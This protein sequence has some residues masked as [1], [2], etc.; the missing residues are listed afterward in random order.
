MAD[1]QFVPYSDRQRFLHCTCGRAGAEVSVTLGGSF[2]RYT[3]ATDSTRRHVYRLFNPRWVL[4]QSAWCMRSRCF[5][6]S[7]C[8]RRLSARIHWCCWVLLFTY[9]EPY[10]GTVP[11]SALTL[12]WRL[13]LVWFVLSSGLG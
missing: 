6:L 13:L 2:G 10:H 9:M 1:S 8:C 4:K 7:C 12:S 11:G 3:R 5:R